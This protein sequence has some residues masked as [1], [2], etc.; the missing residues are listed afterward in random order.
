[1]AKTLSTLRTEVRR[2]ADIET[3]GNHITDAEVDAYVQDSIRTLHSLLVDGT[4][5]QLFAKNAPVLN[6]IGTRSFQLPADFSQLVSVDIRVSNWYVRSIEADPQEYAQLTDLED[7]GNWTPRRHL[8][9]WN[10]EE[11][12]GELFI[13]PTPTSA[14][15]VAVQ[16]IPE[17]P[18]LS[19]DSDTLNWPDFWNQWVVLDAAIQCANKE[20]SFNATNA[21][22][23]ER[24]KT[25]KRIRDHIRSMSVSEVKTIRPWTTGRY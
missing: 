23:L 15:A 8:L 18:T 17:A 19:L 13:F 9:R 20:E 2:K 12:R 1:M 3:D 25:E 21:L 6:Q 24:D 14:S 11:G 16:Y 7:Y 22:M 4:D 5:G 10:L